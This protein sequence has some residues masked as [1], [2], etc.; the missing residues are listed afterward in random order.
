MIDAF[1]PVSR[2]FSDGSQE[3]TK[4]VYPLSGQD[5]YQG[6]LTF[7]VYDEAASRKN[8]ANA[9][10]DAKTKVLGANES[11]AAGDVGAFVDKPTRRFL[12]DAV[13]SQFANS[14]VSVR[15]QGKDLAVDFEK[16]SVQLFLPQQ[17]QINDAAGYSNMDLGNIGY[18]IEQGASII[19]ATAGAIEQGVN[20]FK[21]LF[22]RGLP[23]AS[24]E[25]A[26]VRA[27]R[28]IPVIAPEA[29]AGISQLKGVTVN[30]NTRAQF[31]SVPLREFSF[32]FTLIPKS[33]Q[34]AEMIKKIIR[35][36]RKE[37]YPELIAGGFG[38]KF[39]SRLRIVASYK[40][41]VHINGI[42][43][44]PVYLRSFSV[45]YNSQGQ[46]MHKDGNF[47]SAAITMAFVESRPLSRKDV[48]QDGY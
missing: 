7:A 10:S 14:L 35:W 6:K 41:K 45:A 22:D 42:R 16:G 13:N 30:P 17:L 2:K 40:N 39:P 26:M 33:Q 36:F 47:N 12:Q 44:L 20:D 15:S 9:I 11:A 24:A 3:R 27:A 43:F 31:T 8:Y 38:Y 46:G 37:T 21:S 29:S 34:E 18:S 1:D 48:E 32:Q 25:L 4:L 19:G 23:T 5:D 28:N